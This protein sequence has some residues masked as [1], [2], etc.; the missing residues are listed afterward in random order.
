MDPVN[1]PGGAGNIEAVLER[2]PGSTLGAV[3]CH[4]HPLYGGSMHD[5]VLASIDDACRE[6]GISTLRFNFRG[7]GGSG[8]EHDRGVGE[9]DDVAMLANWMRDEC[10]SDAVFLGG[11]SFGAG[12]ALRAAARV[13]P[14]AVVLVA[15][16][17]AMIEPLVAQ[18]CRALVLLGEHDTIVDAE[19]AAALFESNPQARVHIVRGADHFF[20]GAGPEIERTVAKFLSEA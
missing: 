10:A 17:V 20:M 13:Q 2:I 5:G 16:P 18:A 19:A 8:G 12:I 1:I 4:P 9:S 14:R 15:P 7:V 3:L 6:A 11:Y